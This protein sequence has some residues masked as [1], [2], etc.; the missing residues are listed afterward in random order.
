M[1]NLKFTTSVQ[2][3]YSYVNS[4]I[5]L[6]NKDNEL[7]EVEYDFDIGIHPDSINVDWELGV[8]ACRSN[9]VN[10]FLNAKDQLVKT[11]LEIDRSE[12]PKDLLLSGE[13][14]DTYE[15]EFEIKDIKN[16]YSDVGSNPFKDDFCPSE[17]VFDVREVRQVSKDK[18]LMIVDNVELKF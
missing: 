17:I 10:L 11:E 3:D 15:L 9:H 6:L 4:K 5:K 18:F 8:Y 12:L 16:N 1:E 14:S 7:V 2:H 13:Y